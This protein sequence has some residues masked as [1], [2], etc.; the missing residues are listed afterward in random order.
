MASALR[1]PRLSDRAA[2]THFV[3]GMS[4]Q[5]ARRAA[6]LE[7][8]VLAAVLLTV[9]VLVL[10]S[11]ELGGVA[12]TGVDVANWVLWGVFLVEL[13]VMLALAPD[14]R[15]WLRRNK[16]DVAIVVL[17]PPFL[18]DALQILWVLRLLRILDVM[19]V[20][21]RIF[22]VNGFRYAVTL[23][24]IAAVG[25]GLAYAELEDGPE[26]VANGFDGIYWAITTITTVGYGDVTPNTVAGKLLAEALMLTGPV[27]IGIV[28]ASVG[29]L[30][31]RR[32]QAEAAALRG[33]I[34]ELERH[35]E[36]EDAA[37]RSHER[38][39]ADQL[40]ALTEQVR[41]LQARLDPPDPP[42]LETR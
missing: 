5:Q 37:E 31:E 11:L 17:T 16:L 38:A 22:E 4:E 15:E 32:M 6:K 24:F 9:P 8:P 42:P 20:V 39:V 3:P 25:G 7:L 30:A 29:Q 41:A 35:E 19:P 40:A 2:G 13:V 12:G 18:P 27:L 21:G 33:E 34:D 28:S 10:H 26:G 36:R 23:A 1:L 14:D